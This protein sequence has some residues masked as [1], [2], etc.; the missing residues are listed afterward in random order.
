MQTLVPP[1]VA[2][3]AAAATAPA[4]AALPAATSTATALFGLVA[5]FAVDRAIAA[6]FKGNR[7]RLPATGADD[8]RPGTHPGPGPDARVVMP[9]V[10]LALGRA[11]SPASRASAG[12][13]TLFRL[14]AGFAASRG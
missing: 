8:R 9:A 3:A 6:R 5:A 7:G 13:R 10:M 14:A 1:P 4:A 2:V 11:I 12:I